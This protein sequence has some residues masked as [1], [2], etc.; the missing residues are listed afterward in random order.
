M[1]AARADNTTRPTLK[2][3]R[4][5]ACVE[6]HVE[7]T[8]YPQ[9]VEEDTP[10]LRSHGNL[11]KDDDASVKATSSRSWCVLSLHP[12]LTVLACAIELPE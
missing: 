4:E 7:D 8:E 12:P 9:N 5:R 3:R 11:D 1:Q 10:K 6:Y 2:P